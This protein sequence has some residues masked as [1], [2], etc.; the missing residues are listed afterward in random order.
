[1]PAALRCTSGETGA[2]A[3]ACCTASSAAFACP[4]AR[5]ASAS[6]SSGPGSSARRLCRAAKVA[7]AA[8]GWPAAICAWPRR[9][10]SGASSGK[11]ARPAVAS[12]SAAGPACASSSSPIARCQI[13]A[14]RGSQP[15]GALEQRLRGR[16]LAA[17]QLQAGQGQQ[18]AAVV[19]R[20]LQQRLEAL[21]GRGRRGCVRGRARPAARRRGRTQRRSPAHARRLR[22]PPRA[23]AATARPGRAGARAMRPR[24]AWRP[25]ARSPWP[26]RR[27]GAWPGTCRSGSGRRPGPEG[28][29]PPRPAARADRA[30]AGP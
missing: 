16:Q 26:R 2:S 28:H 5:W 11:A 25:A 12:S 3:S 19:G 21:L 29:W 18:G 14:S 30:P 6:R 20:A 15:H 23:G 27:A 24:A 17:A 1:M 13:P 10:A 22:A 4:A 7:I 8:C 9:S